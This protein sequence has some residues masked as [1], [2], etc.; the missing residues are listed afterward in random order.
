[1]TLEDTRTGYD[2][3]AAAF[4]ERVARIVQENDFAQAGA[5]TRPTGGHK[6]EVARSAAREVR[7]HHL[8]MTIT[9]R[10]I[11]SRILTSDPRVACPAVETKR[12]AI[13]D[14]LEAIAASPGSVAAISMRAGDDMLCHGH[15]SKP[16]TPQA[17]TRRVFRLKAGHQ[18][19]GVF[20]PGVWAR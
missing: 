7:G 8:N 15:L 13:L 10:C 3:L 4:G 16:K 18:M 2:E 5:A 12:K 9:S 1:L 6:Q 17:R 11:V 20:S 19:S 14:D